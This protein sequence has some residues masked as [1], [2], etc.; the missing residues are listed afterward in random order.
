M[1]KLQRLVASM[2][3]DQRPTVALLT[4]SA[5]AKER[6]AVYAGLADGSIQLV[7][8]THAL[9]TDALEFK[10][11]GLAVID[12]QHRCAAIALSTD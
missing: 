8:G 5:K 2:P 1:L 7:M 10:H 12:E 3:E 6:R 9:I 11:L 4:G